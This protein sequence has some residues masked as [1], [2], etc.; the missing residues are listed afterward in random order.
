M[1][2]PQIRVSTGHLAL[3]VTIALSLTL[4]T[5]GAS[6]G[7][8]WSYF[9]D[10]VPAGQL[11]YVVSRACA[12]AALVLVWIQMLAGLTIASRGTLSPRITIDWHRH[13]GTAVILLVL[14]HW[15]LFVTGVSLR[16]GEIGVDYIIPSAA[17][18]FYRAITSLGIISLATMALA[19]LAPLT[20]RRLRFWRVLHALAAVGALGGAIHS[21]LIGSE[22]RMEPVKWL[23]TVMLT[24]LVCAVVWRVLWGLTR[25][26]RP[27]AAAQQ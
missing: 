26:A 17:H 8:L 24:A 18:G 4:S 20:R 1:H 15:T 16:T 9:S 7:D 6:S 21:W 13:L 19:S 2:L 25:W 3:L 10:E 5:W 11:L 12:L 14:M 23:Y 27:H 22:T